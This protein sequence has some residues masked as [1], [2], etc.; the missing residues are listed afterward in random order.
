MERRKGGGV[1]FA[2]N[3]TPEDDA[4][5]R[6]CYAR[7]ETHQQTA[8]RLG[9]SKNAVIG[10]AARLGIKRQD[11]DL[12]SEGPGWLARGMRKMPATPPPRKCQWPFGDP[13]DEDFRLCGRPTVEGKPYCAAHCATA[14]NRKGWDGAEED[15]DGEDEDALPETEEEGDGA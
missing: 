10:R 7:G 3:W 13:R 2:G 4:A 1:T 15:D 8:D 11:R 14:Y 6:A 9:R 12:E 5:L